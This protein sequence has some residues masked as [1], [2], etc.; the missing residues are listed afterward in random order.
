VDGESPTEAFLLIGWV[1]GLCR[2]ENNIYVILIT[3]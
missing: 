3:D 2:K 1:P